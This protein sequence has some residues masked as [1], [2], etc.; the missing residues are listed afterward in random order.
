V[1]LS[2][3]EMTVAALDDS[4]QLKVKFRLTAAD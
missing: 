2:Q 4:G 3:G 1:V